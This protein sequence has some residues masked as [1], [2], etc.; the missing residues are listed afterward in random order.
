M[1]DEE[2]EAGIISV[3]SD[4]LN[5]NEEMKAEEVAVEFVREW[6]GVPTVPGTGR[7][8]ATLSDKS[9]DILVC[10]DHHHH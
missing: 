2:V 7:R 8:I 10:E 4:D 6:D 9:L 1:I 5:E 3:N